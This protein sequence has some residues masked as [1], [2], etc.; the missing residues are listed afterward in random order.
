MKLSNKYMTT[1]QVQQLDT[2][3]RDIDT[4]EDIDRQLEDKRYIQ[5]LEKEIQNA[6]PAEWE[7]LFKK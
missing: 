4:L 7:L 1:Q 3:Y 5:I 6:Q 2:E